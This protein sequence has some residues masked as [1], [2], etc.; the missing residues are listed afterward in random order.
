M[1]VTALAVS[2]AELDGGRVLF[3]PSLPDDPSDSPQR[4][5]QRSPAGPIMYLLVPYSGELRDVIA[6]G[7]PFRT[8]NSHH[9]LVALGHSSRFSAEPSSIEEFACAI[10]SCAS[11]MASDAAAQHLAP[12]VTRIQKW[13]GHLYT[14]VEWE[15]FDV[16]L[17]PPYMYW[18][19]DG[20][21]SIQER[22]LI[23]WR[24][25]RAVED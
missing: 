19:S 13:V 20:T 21:K 14:S 25:S 4:R 6:V 3:S 18:T 11:W 5:M 8:A 10:T 12:G 2:R 24:G 17:K 9:P 23:A 22:D 16:A 7:D 1:N 15:R